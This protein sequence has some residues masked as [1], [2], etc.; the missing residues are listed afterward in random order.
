[1][2]IGGFFDYPYNVRYTRW[3]GSGRYRGLS[4]WKLHHV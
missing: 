2:C 3:V 1:M 4:S